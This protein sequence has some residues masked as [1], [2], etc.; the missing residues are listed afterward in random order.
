MIFWVARDIVITTDGAEKRKDDGDNENRSAGKSSAF[1]RVLCASLWP[2]PEDLTRWLNEASTEGPM[3]PEVR[4]PRG[5]KPSEGV[6]IRPRRF[7]DEARRSMVK[8][9]ERHGVKSS[10]ESMP[11]LVAIQNDPGV[12]DDPVELRR[13]LLD[14]IVE[15]DRELHQNPVQYPLS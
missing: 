12:L 11:R 8:W 4:A 9:A 7:L 14:G 3:G 5:C 10:V 2:D 1:H 13:V 15:G 6:L